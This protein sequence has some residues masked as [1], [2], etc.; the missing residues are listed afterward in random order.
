MSLKHLAPQKIK[1]GLHS[2]KKVGKMRGNLL[3][4]KREELNINLETNQY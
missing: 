4:L 2:W 1:S 3:Q